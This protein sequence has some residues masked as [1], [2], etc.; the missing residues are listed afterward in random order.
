MYDIGIIGGMGPKAT[1]IL[2][3]KIVNFTDANCDQEHPSIIIL[4]NSKIPDRTHYILTKQGS[5]PFD[6]I[7][8]ALDI[9]SSVLKPQGTIG[10]VCNTAH[11]FAKLIDKKAKFY[12]ISFI[13]MPE[14]TLKYIAL[15][16]LNKSCCVLCTQGTKTA[17]IYNQTNHDG[18]EILYPSDK[19]CEEVQSIIY[20]IKDTANVDYIKTALKLARLMEKI[21]DY[22]FILACTELSI[23]DKSLLGQASIVDAMDIL[24][25]MLVNKSGYRIKMVDNRYDEKIIRTM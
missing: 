9:F 10:M 19:Q 12:G 5:S 6:G 4:D 16:N 20:Q 23:L 13:N 24:S 15:S 21:G 22:T 11:Y 18:L 1:S 3:D 14:Y 7:D 25:M 2:F 17:K 8:E